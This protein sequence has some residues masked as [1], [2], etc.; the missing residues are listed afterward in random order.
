ML[1]KGLLLQMV[2]R[3]DVASGLKSV[4]GEQE[5][6]RKDFEVFNNKKSTNDVAA[7]NFSKLF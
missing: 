1:V 3:A 6:E 7:R 5:D 4:A 2:Y